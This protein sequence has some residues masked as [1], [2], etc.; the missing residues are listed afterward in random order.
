MSLIGTD[1]PSAP[2]APP[3][4]APLC[5][6][7]RFMVVDDHPFQLGMTVRHLQRLGADAVQG[8]DDGAAAFEAMIDPLQAADIVILDMSMPGMDGMDVMRK[9]NGAGH[10]F[11]LIINSALSPNLVESLLEIARR[12][13][14][15]LLG[16][17]GKPVSRARLEPLIAAYRAQRGAGP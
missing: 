2:L 16:A 4:D 14:I 15:R 11:S 6:G 5:A 8:F 17:I 12:Y 9:L 10:S 7:L 13:K 1:L 3:E